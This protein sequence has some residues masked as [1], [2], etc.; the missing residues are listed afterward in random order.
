MANILWVFGLASVDKSGFVLA[1]L[2]NFVL[3]LGSFFVLGFDVTR[4][5]EYLNFAFIIE[6]VVFVLL[7]W[8]FWYHLKD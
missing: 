4:P 8:V 3:F 7:A 1:V 6:S 5:F 2:I